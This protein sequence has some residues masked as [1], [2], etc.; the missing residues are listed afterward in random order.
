MLKTKFIQTK[1]NKT[2]VAIYPI[3]GV[4]T[5]TISVLVRAGSWYEKGPNWG[6]FHLL[7]H[8][9]SQ[10]T[11]EFTTKDKVELY[12]EKYGISS[13]AWT[14]G[15]QIGFNLR[16]PDIHIAKGLYFL[17]Q[18]LFHPTIPPKRIPT[19][20]SIITQE[21]QDKWNQPYDKFTQ[22]VNEQLAGRKHIFTRDALGQPE[23]LKS[24]SR[25]LLLK[26]HQQFFQP[27]NITIAIAG[28]IKPSLVKQELKNLLKQHKNTQTIPI[29]NPPK[30]KPKN[31]LI[32]YKSHD[33]QAQILI[34]WFLPNRKKMSYV[35]KLTI[36]VANNI[37]GVGS[38]SLLSKKI[39]EELGLVY[40][41]KS[42]LWT[43]LDIS[44]LEIQSSV[45]TKNI[46]K[47]I[48]NAKLIVEEFIDKG[49]SNKKFNQLN[50]FMDMRTLMNYDSV[51][52]IAFDLASCLFYYNK[53]II[54][55]E[56]VQKASLIKQKRMIKL[57]KNY[58]KPQK[59]YI[60]IMTKD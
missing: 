49:I 2:K 27:Q 59:A 13:D 35:D 39:R 18:I 17:N 4:R 10:G 38:N 21:Y 32:K 22:Q 6:A 23:Y 11:N 15:K 37:I 44:G 60:S 30:I 12:K 8:L 55:E 57:L 52:R 43:W 3:K 9:V 34:N 26:L 46:N 47:L 41:I 29:L 45:D 48:K 19:E 31:H 16:L 36:N 28:N 25:D 50:K 7:E 56:Q 33:N 53:V 24:L 20:I 51:D 1:I 5:V 14:S 58:L 42:R 40:Y 54:P